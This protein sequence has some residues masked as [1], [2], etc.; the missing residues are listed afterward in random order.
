M[1]QIR[2]DLSEKEDIVI[3]LFRVT[4]RLK[5]KSEAIKQIIQKYGKE[6]QK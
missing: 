4:N 1:T 2:I 5:S 3:G 6:Y